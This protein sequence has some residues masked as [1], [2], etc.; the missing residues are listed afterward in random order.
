MAIILIGLARGCVFRPMTNHP[1]SYFNHGKNGIWLGIECVNEAH[2][3]DEIKALA[4]DFKRR[5]IVNVYVYVSYLRQN[6]EFGQTFGYAK[7]FL[8]AIKSA[9][10]DLKVLAW[11]GLP[12]APGAWVDL[13]NVATRDR[14]T[15]F[16]AH[17]VHDIGFD[18]IHLDAELMSDGDP[19]VIRLFDQTRQAIDARGTK[20]ILSTVAHAIWPVLPEAQLSARFGPQFWSGDYFRLVARHVDQIA[21]MTYDSGMQSSFLYRQWLRFQ[22]MN[23]SRALE[24]ERVE[25][26]FGVPTSEEYS[27][28]HHP[29]SENI[30]NALPALIE[31]LN[32]L[33]ARPAVVTGIAIYPH[34]ETDPAEWKVYESLWLGK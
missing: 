28:T 11:I 33:D 30:V 6:G 12:L 3:E 19:N 8:K 16:T 7:D 27:G 34:W 5:Q 29:P 21:V 32:D 25:L 4:D 15:D 1:G 10:P 13:S 2:S 14:I 18:G 20:P 23:I 24:N 17:L 26:L 22:V 31:G 9:N